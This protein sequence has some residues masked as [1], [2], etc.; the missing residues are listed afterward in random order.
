MSGTTDYPIGRLTQSMAKTYLPG[1]DTVHG[2]GSG[3]NPYAY[4][5]GNPEA[6]SDP[7][8]QMFVPPSGGGGGPSPSGGVGPAGN[9]SSPIVD[10]SLV[11][12]ALNAVGSSSG[13]SHNPTSCP[14]FSQ[15]DCTLSKWDALTSVEGKMVALV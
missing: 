8:G 1:E 10:Y 4:V 3:S 13:S 9:V 5:G 14:G 11:A 12:Q 2:N 15:V 7:T 6:Y